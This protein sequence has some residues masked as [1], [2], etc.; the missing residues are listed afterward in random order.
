MTFGE[1]LVQ[2][3]KEKGL[4]Q[5]ALAEQLGTTRQAISKW[6]NGQSYP[7][8][9]KLLMISNLFNVSVDSLLKEN[10]EA[11]EI[12]EHGYYVSREYAEGY[13]VFEKKASNKIAMG[14]SIL[15]G[16]GL[17]YFAPKFNPT[18]TQNSFLFAALIL[19]LGIGVLVTAVF[20]DNPY[21]RISKEVL[22]LDNTF[23]VELKSRYEQQKRKFMPII[24][25]G[26]ILL[27][28]GIFLYKTFDKHYGLMFP[29]REL[30]CVI[31]A[32][33]LYCMIFVI[34]ILDAYDTLLNSTQHMIQL[35][36]CIWKKL[37]DKMLK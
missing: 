21:T 22:V 6:E 24:I 25:L 29:Y 30:C 36:I 31:F 18:G 16:G 35:H 19:I 27:V 9:E 11:H 37:K 14:I 28:G 26:I 17:P 20:M 13:L 7:E 8:T 1:K 10:S 12:N 34:G 23:Y 4:S 33:A 2:L 32:A 15:I 3:R 5:E